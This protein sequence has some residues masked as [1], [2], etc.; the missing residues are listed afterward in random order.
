MDL[1]KRIK[2]LEKRV[3]VLE[4]QVQEQPRNYIESSSI[5]DIVKKIQDMALNQSSISRT[6][7]KTE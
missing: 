1:E 3:A 2:A 6:F 7:V 4:G 5:E